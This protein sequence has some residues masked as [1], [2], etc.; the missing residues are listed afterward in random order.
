MP[1]EAVGLRG[2]GVGL[3]GPG[4]GLRGRRPRRWPERPLAGS[5]WL[6][7][8]RGRDGRRGRG[9]LRVFATG[10]EADGG[11]AGDGGRGEPADPSGSL[12]ERVGDLHGFH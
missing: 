5:G 8:G 10:G 3:R 6:S 9:R 7:G 2:P 1:R 4:V 11:Y 12:S